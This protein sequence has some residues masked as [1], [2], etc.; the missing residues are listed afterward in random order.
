MMNTRKFRCSACG[1]T[2]EILH[3]FPRPTQ[4]PQCHSLYVHRAEEDRG[5][6]RKK[7]GHHGGIAL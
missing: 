6:T 5:Y 2:W 1:H 7:G 4:C 3:G